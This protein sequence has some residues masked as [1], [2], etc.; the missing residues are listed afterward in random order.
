VEFE[1]SDDRFREDR[2]AAGG[3]F[4]TVAERPGAAV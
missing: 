1:S 2:P 3:R 4:A